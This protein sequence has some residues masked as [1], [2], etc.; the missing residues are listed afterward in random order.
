MMNLRAI[1]RNHGKQA[2]VIAATGMVAVNLPYR[3]LTVYFNLLS[4]RDQH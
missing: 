2:S 1:G 3:F 4:W